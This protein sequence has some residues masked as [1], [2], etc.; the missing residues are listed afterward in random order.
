MV[1]WQD[2]SLAILQHSDVVAHAYENQEYHSNT[3][4]RYYYYTNLLP[5]T[6]CLLPTPSCLLP[7]NYY[8]LPTTYPPPPTTCNL[9]P[10][11]YTPPLLCCWHVF[12]AQLA[13]SG[14]M[15]QSA[16]TSSSATQERFAP[17]LAVV[18]VVIVVAV[19]VVV[20][21]LGLTEVGVEVS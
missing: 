10:T 8:L 9:P 5:T 16:A 2:D 6:F 18:V 4:I 11:T 14:K 17:L 21:V 7:T 15:K 3:V 12:S 1:R 19:V 20:A 13:R